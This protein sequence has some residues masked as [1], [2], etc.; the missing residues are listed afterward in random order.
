MA[1]DFLLEKVYQ[2]IRSYILENQQYGNIKLNQNQLAEQLQISRTPVIKA[3]HMLES[4]GLVDNIPNRGFYIHVPTLREIS[5]LFTLRQALEVISASYVC[6]NGSEEDFRALDQCFEKFSNAE[7]IDYDEYFK[8]DIHFHQIIFDL[9]DNRLIHKIN[10][11]LQ[12]MPRV[13]SIG[14]LRHPRETLKEHLALI[15]AMRQRDDIKVRE[16]A[17]LHTENT[18]L[19]LEQLQHQLQSLGLDPDS[20]SAKDITFRRNGLSPAIAGEES[21]KPSQVSPLHLAKKMK[22]ANS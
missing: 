8:A 7:D 22:E 5:E 20:I 4:E 15:Q 17:R 19:Y 2:D 16:L 9:C 10:D 13:L 3:L 14:L 21:I 6:R 12:I 11:S 1:K 18:R